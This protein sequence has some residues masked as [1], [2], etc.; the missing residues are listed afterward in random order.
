MDNFEKLEGAGFAEI[1]MLPPCWWVDSNSRLGFEFGA[2]EDADPR[3]LDNC[4]KEAAPGGQFVFYFAFGTPMNEAVCA[5][6]LA[7]IG[8]SDLHTEM[9]LIRPRQ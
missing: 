6:V 5:E 1:K 9:R 2:V 3:W 4:L 7:R 8:R